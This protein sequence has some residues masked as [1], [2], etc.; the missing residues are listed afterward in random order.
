MVLKSFSKT[1][2]IQ[3]KSFSMSKWV[4]LMTVT[5]EVEAALKAGF[6]KEAGIE[7]VIEPVAFSAYPMA[8]LFKIN[9]A[10]EEFEQAKTV[11]SQ[12]ER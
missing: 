2:N 11:L 5:D 8:S 6:L 10:A 3:P 1:K 4:T 7:C 12:L 9:V